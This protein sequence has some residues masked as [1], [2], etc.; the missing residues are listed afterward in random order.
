MSLNIDFAKTIDFQDV[1]SYTS[2]EGK[3]PRLN[4]NIAQTALENLVLS[5]TQASEPVNVTSVNGL[6]LQ[7]DRKD[8]ISKDPFNYRAS[9]GGT[10]S[11]SSMPDPNN[12]EEMGAY[13]AANDMIGGAAKEFKFKGDV[14]DIFHF[15]WVGSEIPP[16]YMDNIDGWRRA[17]PDSEIVI[18][19]DQAELSDQMGSWCQDADIRVINMYTSLTDEAWMGLKDTFLLQMTK[20]QP[21][22]GEASDIGRYLL[23]YNFG[24][25]YFDTDT[26]SEYMDETLEINSKLPGGVKVMVSKDWYGNVSVGASDGLIST[27]KSPL[28]KE[29]IEKCQFNYTLTYDDLLSIYPSNSTD[30][31]VLESVLRTGPRIIK[32]TFEYRVK[33]SCEDYEIKTTN[34]YMPVGDASWVSDWVKP[35]RRTLS[36]EDSQRIVAEIFWDLQNKPNILNLRKYE[37][38][39]GDQEMRYPALD[40]IITTLKEYPESFSNVSEVLTLE[41]SPLRE[42]PWIKSLL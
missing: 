29:I 26:N 5:S 22:Y 37:Q 42:N 17:N 14:P 12:L 21:N 32:D 27:P 18:W 16:Q 7:Q 8:L 20:T 23:L 3:S 39:I 25:R 13:L 33:S 34:Y 10:P 2:K 11:V 24:G 41:D 9:V 31:N 40:Q 4:P 35:M 6:Q 1:T 36:A 28:F 38:W 15:I 19:T 30:Y